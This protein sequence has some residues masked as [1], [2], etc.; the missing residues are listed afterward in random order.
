M[1]HDPRPSRSPR[2]RGAA[3]SLLAIA[4]L[5]L[6]LLGA[7]GARSE[8]PAVEPAPP[9]AAEASSEAETRAPIDRLY[10]TL[11]EVMQEA[12]AL[13]FEGRYAKLEPVM[14]ET[15]DMEFMAS[16][17][18][19]RQYQRLTPEEQ[20][21]WLKTF[22]QLTISTYADRFDGFAGERLEI[23]AVE[24]SAGG[25]RIVRTVLYPNNDEPVQLDYRMKNTPAGNLLLLTYSRTASSVAL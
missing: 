17:V 9:A 23:G 8:T 22:A 5:A 4:W 1:A 6:P 13:G 16:R 24:E 2:P 19:G 25:T 10:A 3:T 12:E 14:N 18:V 21:L 20:T 11:L 7:P 15:Y